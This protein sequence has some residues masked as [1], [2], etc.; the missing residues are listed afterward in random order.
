MNEIFK[1]VS[2]RKYQDRPV[3][4]DKIEHIL[5]A[6]MAAPSA[7]NQQPWEYYVV[8]DAE[9]IKALAQCSPYAGCAAGA[10][11]VIVPCLKTE[12]LRFPELGQIDL[13]ITT[14]NILLEITSL[15]LGG[16]WLAVAPFEDRIA[17]VDKVLGIEAG[18]HAF[19]LVPLGYPAED[20]PQQNRFDSTRIH[21]ID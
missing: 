3:E 15:G 2:I 6:A 21:H 9:T 7:G 11:V 19:A 16:V 4:D 1:R 8:R 10:P 18:L 12:G 17:E 14:E 20:R 13:S 5:R